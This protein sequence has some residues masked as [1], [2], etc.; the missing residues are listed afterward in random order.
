MIRRGAR[1]VLAVLLAAGL[2][3]CG[4]RAQDEPEILRSPPAPTATPTSTEQPTSSPTPSP[5]D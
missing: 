3:A 4:V 1:A 2:A 5:S